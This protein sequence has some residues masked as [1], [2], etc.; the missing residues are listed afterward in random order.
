MVNNPVTMIARDE[1]ILPFDS[2]A[3]AAM[4]AA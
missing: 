4:G 2:V 3:L 1:A